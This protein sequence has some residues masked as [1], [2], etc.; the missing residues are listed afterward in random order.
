M[1][2]GQNSSA[3]EVLVG[4]SSAP[5]F[6]PFVTFQKPQ[7]LQPLFD[8]DIPK[9]VDEP[10]ELETYERQTV[11]GTKKPNDF[12]MQNPSHVLE[13]E[14]L[15]KRIAE[16]EQAAAQIKEAHELEIA[17]VKRALG[18]ELALQLTESLRVA[19]DQL[20]NELAR[21][22][23]SI[24][25]PF[26]ATQI[27]KKI[28]EAFLTAVKNSL[29]GGELTKATIHGPVRYHAAIQQAFAD[30]LMQIEVVDSPTPELTAELNGIVLS[31]R[32]QHW[33]ELLT[34]VDQ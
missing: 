11:A 12:L 31:T 10:T 26:V 3:F 7:S 24:L 27:R 14:T 5:E 30:N 23:G 13:I 18:S 8:L 6:E 32:F 22:V 4:K 16:L 20:G 2:Q 21:M 19:Q 33:S 29:T 1:P 34:E 15:K 17:E 9:T 28:L 25:E